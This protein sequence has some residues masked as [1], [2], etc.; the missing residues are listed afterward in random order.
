MW[1]KWKL[2]KYRKPGRSQ[3]MA[4]AQSVFIM[5]GV[6]VLF[7]GT[8]YK[9]DPEEA[10]RV[11]MIAAPFFAAAAFLFVLDFFWKR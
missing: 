3:I 9:P 8:P 2:W 6:T 7:F 1:K 11:W 5:V 4:L 10:H